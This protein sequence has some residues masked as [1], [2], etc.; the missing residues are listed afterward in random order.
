[1]APG[2]LNIAEPTDREKLYTID[3]QLKA[4]ITN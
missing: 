2:G 1:M 4:T 3:E